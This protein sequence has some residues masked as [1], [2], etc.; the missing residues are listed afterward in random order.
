MTRA[1]WRPHVLTTS[2]ALG[3]HAVPLAL[4]FHPLFPDDDLVLPLVERRVFDPN[5]GAHR[6]DGFRLV[7][8]HPLETGL[9]ILHGALP[10]M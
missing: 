3:M 9:Q 1:S 8:R 2:L 6:E 4:S 7:D 10:L 5:Q